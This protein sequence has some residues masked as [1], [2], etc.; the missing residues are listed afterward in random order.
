MLSSSLEKYLICLYQM[1]EANKDIKISDL[2]KKMNQP[3]QKTIQALQRMHYQKYVV[4]STYQPLKMTEQGRKMA[5]YLIARNTLIDE[6]F[7]LLCITK[8]KEAE[9]EAAAQY[10]SYDSLINI[11]RFILFNKTYPEIFERFKLALSMDEEKSILPPIPE[12]EK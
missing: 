9:K 10:L 4:Y 3:L 11:E 1:L 5:K 2:S 7:N 12:E 8:N 6:F